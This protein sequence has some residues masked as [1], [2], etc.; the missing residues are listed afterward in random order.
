MT[1]KML[2]GT[3]ITAQLMP[4]P[5]PL[6]WAPLAN[7]SGTVDALHQ[8]HY[9]AIW[10]SRGIFDRLVVAGLLVLW[11]A[12]TLVRIIL[13]TI[14]HAGMAK[15]ASGKGIL[16][17][18]WEQ[19][20]LAARFGFRP[21]YYYKLEL[22]L[23]QCY[24]RAAGYVHRFA[25]K[26]T[27]YRL[28]KPI[29]GTTTPLGDKADFAEYAASKG[30]AV[31]PVIAAF[32]KG[33][34]IGTSNDLP[35]RDLFVKRTRGRG[36]SRAELWRYADGRYRH[37]DGLECDA[38]GL[39]LRLSAL[40]KREPFL[41]QERLVNDPALRDLAQDA[42]ATVRVVTAINEQGEAEAIRAVFRMPSRKGS[43]VDNY[44]AGGI[45][46]AVDLATGRLGAATDKG[47]LKS[48]GWVDRHPVSGAQ[49]KGRIL[50]R[51]PDMLALVLKTH[52]A[53]ADRPIIGW[54]VALTDRGLVI[55]E[56][57]AASDTDIIQRCHRAPLSETRYPDLMY[58]HIQRAGRLPLRIDRT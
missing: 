56:G 31:V 11:P 3:K 57:N 41:V 7:E 20:A 30:I 21:D 58:W 47:F 23:P 8:A 27:L 42:L 25:T 22:Y 10:Q 35:P 15:A 16:R 55:I 17:Q 2:N 4:P 1:T 52:R 5:L 28:L 19:L 38:A 24:A 37:Q 13:A 43:I 12:F 26:D 44:H 51:W 6:A 46:A 40:S 14:P 33:R 53:F 32:A 39:L 45:A 49:I 34:H 54:D 36:G 29:G 50:P 18:A 9:R 48:V